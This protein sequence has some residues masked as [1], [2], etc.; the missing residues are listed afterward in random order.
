M[1]SVFIYYLL[2]IVCRQLHQIDQKNLKDNP[3]E[4][5]LGKGGFGI[6][7]K[8]LYRGHVVAVKYFNS[9]VTSDAVQNEA[10]MLNTFD[11]NGMC[12]FAD[13]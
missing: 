12:K 11:H 1:K 9:N 6:S 7:K 4:E 3:G 8:M 5:I 13:F 2:F 10:K